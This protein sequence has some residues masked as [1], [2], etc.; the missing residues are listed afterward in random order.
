M[1]DVNDTKSKRLAKEA[2]RKGGAAKNM[3]VRTCWKPVIDEEL[4]EMW[5]DAQINAQ[6]KYGAVGKTAYSSTPF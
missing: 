6:I 2:T 5:E 1:L 4:K 3:L